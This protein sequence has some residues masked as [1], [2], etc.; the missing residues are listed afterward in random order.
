M[1][2]C[3]SA[4]TCSRCASFS[5]DLLKNPDLSVRRYSV[6]RSMRLTASPQLCAMS[7]ALEAHGDTVPKRGDTMKRNAS[8]ELAGA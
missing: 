2:S 4:A 1:R 8:P 3:R 6:R 7:V 5:V